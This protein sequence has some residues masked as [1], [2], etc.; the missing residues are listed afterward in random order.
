V[1]GQG[2]P[3]TLEW[4]GRDPSGM[5]VIA[6]DGHANPIGCGRLLPDAHLGRMAVLQAWRGTGIG[7]A[8]LQRLLDVARARGEREVTLHAQSHAARF[9][10]KHGFAITSATFVEAGMPHVEMRLRLRQL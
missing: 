7:S 1:L 4:D 9:Y 3:E 10:I 2:V 8:L 6:E 5:H